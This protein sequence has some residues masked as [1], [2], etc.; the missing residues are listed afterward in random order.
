MLLLLGF[1]ESFL[2]VSIELISLNVTGATRE[3]RSEI[4]VFEGRGHFGP[5][6][7]VF[8]A[9]QRFFVSQH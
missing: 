9:F 7:Q 8:Q 1:L 6:F 5:K 4:A 2:L 3:Y